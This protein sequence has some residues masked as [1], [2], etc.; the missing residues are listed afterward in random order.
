MK[1]HDNIPYDA[2]PQ[3]AD[4][5]RIERVSTFYAALKTRRSCRDFA[6]T[7]VQ[8][9]VI[10]AAL[11]AAGTAPSGA[12]HQPWHFAVI[13][14]P[15]KKRALREAAEA[16]EREFYEGKASQEWIDALEPLGTDHVNPT[17]KPH[18]I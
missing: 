14:S 7:P 3:Y 2:L 9:K 15:E 8:R 12:N 11:L 6:D 13:C 5:Q 10:E 1:P 16:E 18:P 17:W 4:A